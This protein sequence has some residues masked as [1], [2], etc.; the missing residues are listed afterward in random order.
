[1]SQNRARWAT[2]EDSLIPTVG[3]AWTRPEMGVGHPAQTNTFGGFTQQ[4][5]L[6]P[7]RSSFRNGCA[8]W[9]EK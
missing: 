2:V 7:P 8:I 5:Q 6:G 9:S 3:T 4:L 1:M